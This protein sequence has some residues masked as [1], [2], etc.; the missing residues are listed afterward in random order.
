M[1]QEQGNSDGKQINYQCRCSFL[2]VILSSLSVKALGLIS[3][4]GLTID[5]LF[6]QVY[7]EKIGDLLDPTQRDLEVNLLFLL[8]KQSKCH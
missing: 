5:G 7:D 3:L 2:E 4:H 6:M 1:T 8:E